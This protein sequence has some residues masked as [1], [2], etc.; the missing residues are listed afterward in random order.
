MEPGLSNEESFLKTG[1]LAIALSVLLL[2]AGC[3]ADKSA[4]SNG[5][6]SGVTDH[7]PT[8]DTSKKL[9]VGVVFDSGGRGDKSFNDSAYAGITRAE[10]ELG[11]ESKTVDSK[12]QKDYETNLSAMADGGCDLIFA[13]GITQAK[14]LES[15]SAKYPNVKFAII[16]GGVDRPN[17]RSLVFSEEEGSFLAG[18]LAGLVSKTS[19]VG[20]VGGMEIPLI[21]KFEVGYEAGAKFANP[22]IEVLPAKYTNNWDDSGAG[23]SA[24]TVLY[25]S[26]ADIVYHAA[27]RCGQGVIEAAKDMNHFAIGVDSDQDSLAPGHVLTSMVKH[28]D[29]SVYQT[30]KDTIDGKFS[31][32]TKQYDL[33]DKGVG[34]TDFQFTKAVIGEANIAKV[35][36]V[37]DAIVS[38][39]LKVPSK[40][41][42]LAPFLASAKL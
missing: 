1:I 21:K 26:G 40:P 7:G 16:D 29:V 10:K 14:A 6:A 12:A 8:K 34:L 36:K 3:G 2:L 5:A 24:A 18:Y 32:G 33:K 27:G 4:P 19:K 9:V 20:F 22:K 30:I 15:V 37:S 39:K 17:V 41:E 31:A 13:V 42:E 11:I 38:G 28:V 23:R 35:E 25:N